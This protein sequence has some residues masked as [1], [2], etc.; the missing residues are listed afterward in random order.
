MKFLPWAFW[1]S[2]LSMR[3]KWWKRLP[4]KTP[5]IVI[6]KW[7]GPVLQHPLQSV[8]AHYVKGERPG[9]RVADPAALCASLNGIAVVRQ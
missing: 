3:R 8:Y 2:Y 6:T 7:A 5:C 9:K 1:Q 4:V